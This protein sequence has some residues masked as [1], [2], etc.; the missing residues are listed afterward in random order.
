V[1]SPQTKVE[2]W[3]ELTC[4]CKRNSIDSSNPSEG[5][6]T[7]PPTSEVGTPS[8]ANA[9]LSSP[10]AQTLEILPVEIRVQS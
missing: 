1:N 2:N 7:S 4:L 9:V 8:K 6:K 5:E 3:S 10:N